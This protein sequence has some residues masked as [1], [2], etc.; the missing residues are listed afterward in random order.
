[1]ILNDIEAKCW[2]M[3]MFIRD[4]GERFLLGTAPYDF[5]DSQ[6]HFTADSMI[7]DV[8]EIQ[9]NDGA[10]LAGQVR[11]SSTQNFDGFIG[12][13]GNSKTTIEAYRR[14]FLSFFAKNHF[15]TVVY[16]FSDHTASKRQRGY[17]VDSPE[18]RELRQMT[19][20]YHIAFNFEDVNYY[21]YAENNDGDEI[22]SGA[23]EVQET[24]EADGGLIWEPLGNKTGIVWDSVGATWES[25]NG[26]GATTIN[27]DS[28]A[29]TY[30]VITI[31]GETVNPVIEN[32]DTGTSISYNGT[33]ATGQTLVIDN[34]AQTATLNGV[35]I[36]EDIDGDWFRLAPGQNRITYATDSSTTGTAKLEWNEVVG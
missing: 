4:D 13:F 1:M 2:I 14:Q 22:Y 36:I 24:G 15:Y 6:Q 20:E 35:S 34:N 26:G 27:L 8:V 11:R 7:N 3:A 31:V 10:L 29:D 23:V 32:L 33:I 5:K 17:I 16:I 25:G 28:T 30:P 12:E 19:P 18:V 21:A 9:G